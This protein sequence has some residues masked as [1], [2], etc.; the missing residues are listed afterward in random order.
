MSIMDTIID[1]QVAN[2]RTMNCPMI[3]L[4]QQ[5]KTLADATNNPNRQF[6]IENEFRN[7]L[8]K[9]PE[10]THIHS[11]AALAYFFKNEDKYTKSQKEQIVQTYL[12][13]IMTNVTP[14]NIIVIKGFLQSLLPGKRRAGKLGEHPA[15]AVLVQNRINELS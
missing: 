14:E 3:I 1:Q 7:A 12:N 5:Y 13:H 4:A 11:L 2:N 6:Q 15:V 9:L 10:Y 8:V